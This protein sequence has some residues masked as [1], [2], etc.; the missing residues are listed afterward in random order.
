MVEICDKISG[1]GR[2]APRGWVH[3]GQVVPSGGTSGHDDDR[4]LDGLLP[5]K[6]IGCDW[7]CLSPRSFSM[8]S[9]YIPLSIRSKSPGR[10][11]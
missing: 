11:I 7:D 1:R 4:G 5:G 6:E 9:V 10:S 3:N 2:E 8:W